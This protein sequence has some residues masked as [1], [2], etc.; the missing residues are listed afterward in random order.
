L[1][2]L[3]IRH[4]RLQHSPV[5]ATVD[6]IN[7]MHPTNVIHVRLRAVGQQLRAWPSYRGARPETWVNVEPGLKVTA[8]D[9]A[10]KAEHTRQP[11]VPTFSPAFRMLRSV[12][13]RRQC[14]LIVTMNFPTDLNGRDLKIPRLDASAS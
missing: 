7:S 6:E 13:S 9:I 12:S 4:S 11:G 8:F 3:G 5:G 2:E 10:N 1:T 14:D